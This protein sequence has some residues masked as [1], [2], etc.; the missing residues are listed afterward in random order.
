MQDE[1]VLR[2]A[3]LARSNPAGFNDFLQAFYGE[4][5]EQMAKAVNASP[6]ML[7]KAC[8]M[9]QAYTVLL[10]AFTDATA[11]ADKIMKRREEAEARKQQQRK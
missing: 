10:K 2:T 8:G 3:V 4:T 1:L 5:Q 7:A 6:D 9:A 11:D